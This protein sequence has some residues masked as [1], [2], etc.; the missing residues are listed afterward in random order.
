MVV[1][2][3]RVVVVAILVFRLSFWVAKVLARADTPQ[4]IVVVVRL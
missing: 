1:V 2:R 3:D 4:S